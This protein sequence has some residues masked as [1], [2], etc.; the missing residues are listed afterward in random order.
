MLCVCVRGGEGEKRGGLGIDDAQTAN[1]GGPP[2]FT[3]AKTNI[4]VFTGSRSAVMA[5][6]DPIVSAMIAAYGH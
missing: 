4:D 3:P 1:Q 6:R 5:D 2:R